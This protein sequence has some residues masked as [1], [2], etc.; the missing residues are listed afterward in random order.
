MAVY[1]FAQIT[2]YARAGLDYVRTYEAVAEQKAE[3]VRHVCMDMPALEVTE[4]YRNAGI[5]QGQ[6]VNMYEYFMSNHDAVLS[7][8]LEDK[9][10]KLKE[11]LQCTSVERHGS[12]TWL[13]KGGYAVVSIMLNE[14]DRDYVHSISYFNFTRLIRSEVY[15]GNTT[16]TEHFKTARSENG[17]LYA[18]LTRRTFLNR[19]NSVAFDQIFEE[20]EEWYLFPNG[21][22]YTKPQLMVEFVKRL[23]LS[24]EDVILL[25]DSVSDEFMEAVFTFGKAAR[26]VVLARAGHHFEIE[27]TK[28]KDVGILERPILKEYPYKWFR[29]A[30][31]IDTLAVSTNSQKEFLKAELERCHCRIPNIRTAS[32]EGEFTYAVL[33]ESYGG[34]MALSWTFHG[35][36]DGFLIYDESGHQL[37]ETRNEHQHYYLIKR[38][39]KE[40]GFVVKAF[41]DTVCGRTVM[42]ESEVVYLSTRQYEKPLVSLIIP[43]YNA[44][45]YIARTLDNA[46]AQSLTDLEIIAVD[47]ECMDSTPKI[48]EW[49]AKKYPNVVVIHK[50]NGGVAAARNTGIEAANGEYISFVDSDDTMQPERMENLYDLV[51][52]NDCDIAVTSAYTVWDNSFYEVG[53]SYPIEEKVV[54][55][56][57]KFFSNNGLFGLSIVVWNK[58]YRTSL[59]KKH[60][61]PECSYEDEAWTPYILSY[62]DTICYLD[63][64]SYEWNRVT[65]ENSLS[66]RLKCQT[67]KEKFEDCKRAVLFYLEQGNPQKIVEL[68]EAARLSLTAWE[69]QYAYKEYGK[70]WKWIDEN[71]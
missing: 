3:M 41:A 10:E 4:T 9:L 7:V 47:D 8:R 13:V 31:A 55:T 35:K 22:R 25:D 36:P 54:M 16:Y 28:N 57:E 29:Y 69:S 5:D 71:F 46:L 23:D 1:V 67:K 17:G 62:A 50:E 60:L 42:A 2:E 40:H 53:V 49:Y 45:D 65:R 33:H 59:L 61:F 27:N 66:E 14:K 26:I 52:K 15:F 56:P 38:C 34:N 63:D 37:C 48:L 6:I 64:R 70:L 20:G 39:E 43:V 51:I 11:N 19:D 21:K 68:K 30:E 24:K 44:E 58:L 12:E 18:K 32:I